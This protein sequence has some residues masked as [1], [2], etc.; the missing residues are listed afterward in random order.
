[1]AQGQLKKTKAPATKLT[2]RKQTGN[3]VIK[4]KKTA[5]Q[6]QQTMNK[7]HTAGLAAMTEKSLAGRAGHLE[8]LRGGKRDGRISAKGL[9]EGSGKKD[10]KAK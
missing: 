6:K 8:L 3:R 1:M 9:K 4:P 10:A 2:Q 7:K 5:L